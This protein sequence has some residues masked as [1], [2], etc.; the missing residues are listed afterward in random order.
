MN[1]FLKVAII[2]GAVDRASSV[3]DKF[4]NGSKKK[5]DEL[6]KS[7]RLATNLN[8]IGQKAT[9]A[10]AAMTGYFA[11]TVD[12][13][14][15]SEAATRKLDNVFRQM[16]ETTGQ[17]SSQAAAYASQLQLVIGREDE[18]IMAVQAKLATFKQ[19]SDAYARQTGTFN[20]LTQAAFD[21]EAVGFGDA[22]GNI[23]Q[24]G[25]AF[26][27]P[28]KGA[29]ALKKSGTLTAA[30]VKMV[31][32]ITRQKGIRAAQDYMLKAIERQVKGS[33][34]A[35]SNP[36][37]RMKIQYGEIAESVGKTLIPAL[38]S[39]ANW[40]SQV[41]PKIQGFI[42][43]NPT[44]VK[45][46]AAAGVALMVLGPVLMTVA[47]ATTVFSAALWANP[48]TWIIVG[49]MALVAAIVY[50]IYNWDKVTLFF[51]A[52][53]I[54][55][56]N[57]FSNGFIWIKNMFLKYTGIGLVMKYWGPIVGF[58]KNLWQKVKDTISGW[59]TWIV[60]LHKRMY[61]AGA[62]IVN[63]IWEG[64]K[65]G[66]AR[67]IN[68]FA[69]K[70]QGIRDYLPFS[71]AKVGPLKDIHRIRL[72]ETVAEGIKPAAIVSKMNAA[73]GQVR[74]SIN[75]GGIGGGAGTPSISPVS[76]GGASINYAPVVTIA[77][78]SAADKTAFADMLSQHKT[79][80]MRLIKSENDRSKRLSY[81]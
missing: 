36:V 38:R 12:A 35:M 72:M 4:V 51:K 53:W 62:N 7:Q 11:T 70:I 71:P 61:N 34:E 76:A 40:M 39:F 65:S 64:M 54:G 42:E 78:G 52:T 23:A 29:T 9:I 48:I 60:D 77:G 5:F 21:M 32:D 57:I 19:A 22:M 37:Q 79:E 58:F 20:R 1:N 14:M 15:E 16:G 74:S 67:M 30:E 24:L 59:F 68:W 47:A 28:I 26:Q 63:S 73:M 44:L 46:F 80:L 33:A 31:G 2:L 43:R 69:K 55:W 6:S 49:I 41:L 45:G 27:D 81:S 17:A 50:L 13:A 18:E 25:K 75:I 56:K 66:W 3:I 10:G 8:N